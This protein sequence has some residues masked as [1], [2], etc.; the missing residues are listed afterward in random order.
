MKKITLNR[1]GMMMA[2]V[3]PVFLLFFAIACNKSASTPQNKFLTVHLTDDPALFN[4]V[5]IDVKTV[6]VKIDPDLNHDSHFDDADK[7][8]DNDGTDHDQFGKWDTLHIRPGV[9]DIMKLRNGLDTVLATGNIPVGRI[10][11]IR[12]TVGSNNSVVLANKVSQ[13]LILA[14]GQ[15]NYLYVKID[16]K[17]IDDAGGQVSLWIDFD[18]SESIREYN[19]QFY[20]KPVLKAFS[21]EQSGSIE[22]KV[23]P[24]DAHA[25]VKA[26]SGTD[27]ATAI[28]ETGNG[29]FKIRG[30]KTGTYS[31]SFKSSNGYRDT[32]ITNVQVMKGNNTELPTVTL[33]K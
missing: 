1:F 8:S 3:L 23:L 14:P 7:D 2:M 27:T 22:G 4:D 33:H 12:I 28:P 9:S 30:L 21:M 18:L 31:V 13:P 25:I 5:F 19:G 10:E 29:E 20:L 16:E 17:E 11:K 32:T 15:N 6:E 26:Y 24:L